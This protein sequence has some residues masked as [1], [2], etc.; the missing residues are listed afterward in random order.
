[1]IYDKKPLSKEKH[2]ELLQERGLKI[3]DK[4]EVI[5][6]LNYVNYYR[7]SVYFIPFQIDRECFY[8]GVTFSKVCDLYCFDKAFRTLLTES[9][10]TIEISVRT[11]LTEV[12]TL[13][14][15]NPFPHWRQEVFREKFW[16]GEY[17][18]WLKKHTKE[19]KRSKEIF[20]EHFKAKYS[21]EFPKL[22]L[23]A[24]VEIMSLGS[25]SLLIKGLKSS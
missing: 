2:V 20:I 22:P 6:F 5:L 4:K 8:E 23:W 11:K 25:L 3:E 12:L 10:A 9:L 15:S 14:T 1:M 16:E 17:N 19:A 13:K 24:A 21:E 18:P 7:L